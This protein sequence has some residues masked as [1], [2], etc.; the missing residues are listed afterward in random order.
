M[1]DGNS[2]NFMCG[3]LWM[4][5]L[6]KI[7]LSYLDNLNNVWEGFYNSLSPPFLIGTAG[8]IVWLIVY[9]SL[10]Y[11]GLDK[12]KIRYLLSLFFIFTILYIPLVIT[13]VDLVK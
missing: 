2:N 1:S 3:V 4:I 12:I 11:Y 5:Y 8:F 13:F 10:G 9:A 6:N 7:R